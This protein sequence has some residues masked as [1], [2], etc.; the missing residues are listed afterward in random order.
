MTQLVSRDVQHELSQ[1][2]FQF[3]AALRGRGGNRHRQLPLTSR[4]SPTDHSEPDSLGI[5]LLAADLADAES[6][7][8]AHALGILRGTDQ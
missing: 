1:R 7:A 3:S 4:A 6:P 8:I 2:R 5:D